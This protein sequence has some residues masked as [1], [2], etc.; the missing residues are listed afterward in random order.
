MSAT[1]KKSKGDVGKEAKTASDEAINE[2]QVQVVENHQF[3]LQRYINQYRGVTRV[4]RLLWIGQ[5]TRGALQIEAFRS[6]IDETKRGLN[7]PMYEHCVRYA[8]EALGSK[9]GDQY[10]LD[11]SW[12]DAIR[13]QGHAEFTR[14]DAILTEAKRIGEREPIRVAYI[15]VADHQMKQGDYQKS[16]S[17]YLDTKDHGVTTQHKMETCLN[18]IQAAIAQL[19]FTHVKAQAN[20][21]QGIISQNA[22]WKSQVSA[23]MGLYFLKSGN[24][25]GAATQFLNCNVEMDK[26]YNHIISLKDIAIYGSFCALAAY[27]RKNLKRMLD[28]DG[29]KRFLEYAPIWKKIIL[30]FVN[31][32][33]AECFARLEGQKNNLLLDMYTSPHYF[34]MEKRIRDRAFQ[35]Y[36]RPFKSVKIP[37]MAKALN[38]QVPDVERYL[39]QLIADN[40]VQGRID[41]HNK[42]L[43]SR[44]ADQRSTTYQ[45]SLELGNCYVRDVKALLMRMSLIKADFVVRQTQKRGGRG[46]MFGAMGGRGDMDEEKQRPDERSKEEA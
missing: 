18:I 17:N 24:F 41:S 5:H 27:D 31:S 15:G 7:Y 37:S 13:R 8:V 9:L 20:R 40:K 32:S 23:A 22:R 4:R 39:V 2:V 14:L 43:F 28:S 33:Y 46:G 45:E 42:I 34:Q 38:M 12:V 35:Q 36:F 44:V 25:H 30:D 10:L 21:V 3:N 6:A 11:N 29:W 16:L 19:S 1:T 26:S